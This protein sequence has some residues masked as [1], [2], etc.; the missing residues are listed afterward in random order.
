MSFMDETVV[1][2]AL[3]T[4]RDDLGLSV[5]LSH[6][7]PNAYILAFASLAAAGG[8]LGDLFGARRMF[9]LGTV[10]FAVASLLCGLADSGGMLVAARAAQGAAAAAMLPQTMALLAN[11]FPPQRLGK[12]IGTYVGAASVALAAGPL[13]G[14]L[15]TQ[16]LGW[17]AIFFLNL[18]PAS[19]VLLIASLAIERRPRTTGRS[20][21]VSARARFDG[22]GLVLSVTGLGLLV[23]GIM[24]SAGQSLPALWD[25]A[26]LA[27][28]LLVLAAFVRVEKRRARPLVDVGLLAD[29]RFLGSAVMVLCAQFSFLAAVIYGAV[30]VQ[31]SL[32]LKPAMAGLALLPAMLPTVILAPFTGALAVRF[33]GRWLTVVGAV[34]AALGFAFMGAAVGAH[35]YWPFGAALL[36][37]GVSIPLIYNPAMSVAM[38]A[39]PADRRGGASGLLEMCLQV[40]GTLGTA[41]VGAILVHVYAGSAPLP[42]SAFAPGFYLTAGVLTVAALIQAFL[43]LSGHLKRAGSCRGAV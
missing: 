18:I 25:L 4:V 5:A 7:V 33:G 20:G 27:A 8:R 2:V 10:G 16:S 14:G 12:A 21:A 17:R 31:D 6:W 32:G 37:W 30:Y 41:V 22:W 39:P 15:V 35:T 38:D 1:G 36:L 43:L 42:G 9:L 26:L 19:A 24:E 23:T 11:A 28:G 13:L 3:P 40:G 29:H 34:G